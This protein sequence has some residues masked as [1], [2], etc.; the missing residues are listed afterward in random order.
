MDKKQTPVKNEYGGEGATSPSETGQDTPSEK[1]GNMGLRKL[2]RRIT[3]IVNARSSKKGK[4]QQKEVNDKDWFLCLLEECAFDTS[5]DRICTIEK[6]RG[7]AEEKHSAISPKNYFR[8]ILVHGAGASTSELEADFSP[9]W[10]LIRNWTEKAERRSGDSENGGAWE[11]FRVCLLGKCGLDKSV[12]GFETKQLFHKHLQEAHKE[13]SKRALTLNIVLVHEEVEKCKSDSASRRSTLTRKKSLTP[14]SDIKKPSPRSP[15]ETPK[16]NPNAK[17]STCDCEYKTLKT[18][19]KHE[20]TEYLTC[21]Q[22]RLQM[23]DKDTPPRVRRHS[24]P[25]QSPSKT[26]SGA[27]PVACVQGECKNLDP[28]KLY[29][30]IT[31]FENHFHMF[32]H[33]S[34]SMSEPEYPTNKFSS[35]QTEGSTTSSDPHG[36]ISELE[37]EYSEQPIEILPME[38]GVTPSSRIEDGHTSEMEWEYFELRDSPEPTSYYC[39]VCNE[40][41]SSKID[42]KNHAKNNHG[43]PVC[44]PCCEVFRDK[45]ELQIHIHRTHKEDSGKQTKY[46]DLK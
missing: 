20:G 21:G 46:W 17:C 23:P 7:H 37:W 34:R 4:K 39:P 44:K 5:L 28:P 8:L 9:L 35:V 27:V 2:A 24:I 25:V 12:S 14:R 6:H 11:L 30:T 45:L 32:H 1:T 19:K 36:H 22:C 3:E 15:A 10:N 13:P 31:D 33:A 29:G 40:R 38:E 26:G 16:L 41:F 18:C 42:L 43:C